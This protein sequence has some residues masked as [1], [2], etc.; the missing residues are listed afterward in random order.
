M[1]C[2]SCYLIQGMTE[3]QVVFRKKQGWNGLMFQ[4][5]HLF[6]A[7]LLKRQ[8]NRYFWSKKLL[9][10]SSFGEVWTWG[11]LRLSS[12]VLESN[13]KFRGVLLRKKLFSWKSLLIGLLG[14]F[15]EISAWISSS[16]FSG[17]EHYTIIFRFLLLTHSA[18]TTPGLCMYIL[19]T[20]SQVELPVR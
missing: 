9:F 1:H 8:E 20:W 12:A 7:R 2:I 17:L 10:G 13:W 3:H 19:W 14:R 18:V 4:N 6:P 5:Y 11:G 16:I 15:W